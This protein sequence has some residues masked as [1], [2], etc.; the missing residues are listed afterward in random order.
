MLRS[1]T[2]YISIFVSLVVPA[3]AR[4]QS[5]AGVRRSLFNGKDLDG[6]QIT[7][8][9]ATVED[10][11]LVLKSGNG[12]VRTNDQYGD[13]ILELEWRA[14]KDAGWDSGIFFRCDLPP[15]GSPW[16]ARHQVN[17]HQGKEGNVGGLPGAESKGLVR[18]GQWNRFKL[19]A[20]G[21]QAALEINGKPAWRV[22]GVTPRR[23]YLGLQAEVPQGGQFEFRNLRILTFP[24]S[25]DDGDDDLR[26]LQSQALRQGRSDWGH[27]G[28]DRNRYLGWTR[29]SNRLIPIYTFGI[30]LSSVSGEHSPYRDPQRLRRLYGRLPDRT[31]NPRAEYFDQT[32]VYQLQKQALAAGK[33]YIV[34][35]VFD[36]TDWE[37]TRAAA[38]Y[39]SG[40]LYAAGRGSG[41]AFQDYRGVETDFGYFVTSPHNDGT[42]ADVNAQTVLVAGSVPGGYDAQRGGETPWTPPADPP[43][44]LGQSLENRQAVTD[45]ASSATSLTC[46]IKTYNDA[47]NVDAE[48]RQAIPLARELQ[49]RGWAI[50]V[51]TSVPIS[52]ATP[53]AAYANNVWRDDYQDL[54]RDLLGLPSVAHRRPLPG[55]DVL[56]GAGWGQEAVQ[57]PGQGQNFVPGNK[58]LTADDLAAIDVEHGG[59]YVVARRTPGRP[60]SELLEH[61]AER[62][63]RERRRLFGFFG[64]CNGH[65][66]FRTAD[67]NYN[68]TSGASIIP[69]IYSEADRSENPTLA[70]LTRAALGVLSTN[71]T[72]F[73]LMVEAGDVDWANHDDNL[74]N[75]IGAVLSGDDAFRAITDWIEA[76]DAWQETAV[77]VTADHGHFL[78]L[79]DPQRLI[80]P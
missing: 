23:G 38:I 24:D 75:S 19:S 30:S 37:T 62:A 78:V 41:L 66:P 1:T 60:G 42:K 48:G 16:P 32:D 57:D 70:D 51:V 29:H 69:E 65:L 28:I 5:C 50:G 9:E 18:D 4:G 3:A 27:W 63:L 56:L 64:V 55:V 43:Y 67:G 10:G 77:I 72:G 12:L 33:K 45:S 36:G 76:R 79:E 73:W 40:K 34:L 46:G 80:A 53:A 31:L 26:Q 22:G 13:F 7:G 49:E 21:D 54:S 59:N 14:R 61:A 44:L 68:P 2:L 35:V 71:E 39:R 52:H 6:W 11:L 47:I 20:F 25:A 17:L 15:E 8:C 58:Y 74:D